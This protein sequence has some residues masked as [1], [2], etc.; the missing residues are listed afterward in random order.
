MTTLPHVPH[1]APADLLRFTCVHCGTTLQVP[2]TL[3]GVTGPCPSC[4]AEIT[5]P[6]HSPAASGGGGAQLFSKPPPRREIPP[7]LAPVA[8]NTPAAAAVRPV[9]IVGESPAENVAASPRSPAPPAARTAAIPPLRGKRQENTATFP[10]R[11]RGIFEDTA[12]DADHELHVER[13]PLTFRRRGW[14]RWLDITVVGAFCGL[15]I[16]C[17][18]A[19][20]FTEPLVPKTHPGLPENLTQRVEQEAG[21]EK[22]R[23]REA[24]ELALAS[25]S[26]YLGAASE[27]AA[28]SHLLPPPDGVSL[29]PF[30]PFPATLPAAWELKSSRRIAGTDR[31]L[32]V[33]K[34]EAQPGPVFVVEQTESGPRL[35]SGAITQQ[36]AGLFQKF[37]A[38]PGEGEGTFYA[39][40]RP[41]QPDNEDDY[42]RNRPDLAAFRFVDV[43]SAFP[44]ES[45]PFIA[46][47]KPDS[48]AAR[49]FARRAHDP[50]WRPAL[51]QVRWQRHRE[52][53]PYVELVKFFTGPWSGE[54]AMPPASATT[55]STSR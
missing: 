51:V 13:R 3:A 11:E 7:P 17:L 5:A 30:P 20:R 6:L 2:G 23:R 54:P 25:V 49:Q 10:S 16:A 19:L 46:C 39:E 40:V 14:Q 26:R 47:M 9:P 52:A 43:G 53:G 18:A 1:P 41:S 42:R 24:G 29:P 50:A 8:E 22:L 35:H 36:S 4:A 15:G 32:V 28:A 55:A 21:M 44:V 33:V 45:L 48:E 31:Y 38:S 34:P 12:D 37:T 27:P